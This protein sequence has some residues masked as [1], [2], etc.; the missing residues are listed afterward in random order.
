MSEAKLKILLTCPPMLG[1]ADEF[2]ALFAERG[3]EL[4]TPRVV[5]ILSEDELVELL[6][7]F[8]GWIAGDDPASERVLT[9]GRAGKLRA[10]V[11]WGV[12]IDNVDLAAVKKLG[13]P[14]AHTPQMFGREVA[15]LAMHYVVALARETYVI[16][17]SVRAGG[18]PKPAGIS[19]MD[20]TAAL[21]GHGDIGSNVARRL[22]AADMRV[23]VY[24]PAYAGDKGMPSVQWPERLEEADFIV[25]TCPLNQATRHMFS[26]AIF[27][28]LRPGVRV[29]NVG[30]GPVIDEGALIEA[31]RTG[32]VHS[33]AL[34]VFED[35]PLPMD[36]ELRQFGRCVFSS[37]N[38]SNTSDARRRASL[39]AM[40]K[41]FEML[42]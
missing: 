27:P 13:L 35:E 30:R 37:H 21:V 39:V 11:K 24:D 22:L 5:Q 10:L 38:G 17:R 6:P 15:D 8:D 40:D 23:N 18:W 28:R 29:V 2:R 36:S 7:Q 20:R 3:A 19:L 25:F 16:D 4:I 9:A 26:R 42:R 33:A 41:L 31:L 1:M 14:F 12:G 34:D 32:L